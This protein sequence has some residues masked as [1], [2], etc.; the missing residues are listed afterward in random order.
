MD[1]QERYDHIVTTGAAEHRDDAS[2]GGVDRRTQS[3]LVAPW[4][5]V[6]A[7]CGLLAVLLY[8]LIAAAPLSSAQALVCRVCVRA[9]SGVR[10]HGPVPRPSFASPNSDS[11][12]RP[13]GRRCRRNGDPD[14]PGSTVT[15]TM[16]RDPVSETA[17]P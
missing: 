5:R 7:G 9:D 17:P 15:Q 13:D 1:D 11:R 4:A 8:T 6:G 16:V 14:A 10:L 3:A 12:P 2:V